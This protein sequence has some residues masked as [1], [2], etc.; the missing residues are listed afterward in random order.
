MN[1]LYNGLSGGL[2]DVN[3]A[4]VGHGLAGDDCKKDSILNI[5]NLMAWYDAKSLNVDYSNKVLQLIDKS[6][7]GRHMTAN[8]P[9]QTLVVSK[10]EINA[11][12]STTGFQFP[13]TMDVSNFSLFFV[14]SCANTSPRWGLFSYESSYTFTNLLIDTSGNGSTINWYNGSL[15]STGISNPQ[16]KYVIL[17]FHGERGNFK[18][19]IQNGVQIYNAS[20][21]SYTTLTNFTFFGGNY[22]SENNGAFKELVLF[23]NRLSDANKLKVRTILNKKHKIY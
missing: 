2:A 4:G 21:G 10:Y 18:R 23:N 22:Y 13:F 11:N 17:E 8:S 12:V 15:N 3:A 20:F 7:N 9:L 14:I 19:V 1:G 6:G 16:N 5:P